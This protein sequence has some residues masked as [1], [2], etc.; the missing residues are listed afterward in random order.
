MK[1]VLLVAALVASAAQ[2]D[3]I[4]YQEGF[5]NNL[6]QF[7]TTSSTETLIGSLGLNSDSTGLAFGPGG[8]LYAHERVS[9]SLYT[10]N[11][12]TAATTLVGVTGIDA[13]DFTVALDGSVGYATSNGG[14]YSINLAT[15][16]ATLLGSPGTLDGL[17]TAPVAVNVNGTPYAAGSIFGIDSRSFFYVDI[18][19][20]TFTFLGSLSGADETLDFGADGTLYGHGDDG[21]LYT[22]PLNPLSSVFLANTTPGLVFGMAVA[23]GDGPAVPEPATWMM[24]IAGFGLVGFA[25]RRRAALA[26]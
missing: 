21:A 15:G 17:T 10:V 25:V 20:A 6:W 16:A 7:D 9:A 5:S 23:P 12:A 26:A 11:T 4:Y 3:V 19:A 24:L 13:E 18:A 2:A 22:N 1:A 8:T 14:L